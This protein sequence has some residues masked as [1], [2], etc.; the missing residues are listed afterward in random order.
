MQLI[1]RRSEVANSGLEFLNEGSHVLS[2]AAV[3]EECTRLVEAVVTRLSSAS[4]QSQ[5]AVTNLVH[6]WNS[7][8]AAI[9][10]PYQRAFCGRAARLGLDPFDTGDDIADQ[11]EQLTAIL[12]DSLIDE[13]CDASRTDQITE[14]AETLRKFVDAAQGERENGGPWENVRKQIRVEGTA[15]PWRDGYEQAA[16][17]R[18]CLGL[19]GHTPLD[20]QH[21]LAAMGRLNTKDFQSLPR[22]EGISCSMDGSAPVFGIAAKL[23]QDSRRFLLAR[24]IGNYFAHG[25]SALVTKGRS[26]LQQRNRAFA[27][28]FLAP[29]DSIRA[30]IPSR[31][32]DSDHISELAEEFYVSA[33]V[34]RRQIENH[35]LAE[36][37]S[38]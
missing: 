27:A 30:R 33:E 34:I 11:I 14:T 21:E 23:R 19:N 4:T 24:A 1:W 3:Q 9:Q 22:I 25:N 31:R 28:E 29:A 2:K 26:E 13:F 35:E 10:N 38:E 6:H 7:V 37:V 12:P 32:L 16:K 36:I 17:L 20:L 8:T 18:R 5:D 15:I